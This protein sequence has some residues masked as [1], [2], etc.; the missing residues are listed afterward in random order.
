MGRCNPSQDAEA[1]F[2]SAQH[3]L[4]S[5]DECWLWAGVRWSRIRNEVRR[6][7]LHTATHA[8]PD[9]NRWFVSDRAL[10]HCAPPSSG[11]RGMHMKRSD[12]CSVV[13]FRLLRIDRREAQRRANAVT[14]M[15]SK[16]A[17][18]A[19]KAAVPTAESTTSGSMDLMW[20]KYYTTRVLE[21]RIEQRRDE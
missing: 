8:T 21:T 1:R 2:Q 3:R 13:L 16:E 15:R 17:I 7:K 12:D 20:G 5:R 19:V 14:T 10:A 6:K 9:C 11:P 4:E 18:H